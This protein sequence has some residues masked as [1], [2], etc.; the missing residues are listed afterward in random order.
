M[1]TESDTHDIEISGFMAFQDGVSEPI[2]QQVIENIRSPF[3][4]LSAAG[5]SDPPLRR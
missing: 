3:N 4:P 2:F 1:N 5:I